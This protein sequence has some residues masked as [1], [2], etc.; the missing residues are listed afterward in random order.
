MEWE[1]D[2]CSKHFSHRLNGKV[3]TKRPI[4]MTSVKPLAARFYQLKYWY[5]PTRD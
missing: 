2:T 1:A 4:P 3:G 5:V